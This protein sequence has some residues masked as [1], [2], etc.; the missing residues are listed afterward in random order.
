MMMKVLPK[1]TASISTRDDVRLDADIYRP[2][3]EG[4]F[5]VILM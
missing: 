2:D 5:P 3:A 4:E 1:E